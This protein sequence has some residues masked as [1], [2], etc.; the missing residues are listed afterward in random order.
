MEYINKKIYYHLQ[1]RKMWNVGDIRFV[2]QETNYYNAYFDHNAHNYEDPVTHEVIPLLDMV[3]YLEYYL[4]NGQKLNQSYSCDII[5][6]IKCIRNVLF[7]YARFFREH[8]F[9]EVRAKSFP[10]YPS[11]KTGL[12]VISDKSDI[13]YWIKTLGISVSSGI[14]LELSLTGKIHEASHESIKLNTNSFN[15]IRHQGLKYWMEN[16]VNK[17]PFVG[18]ECIFEGVAEVIKQTPV[19][20]FLLSSNCSDF[21]NDKNLESLSEVVNL[22]QLKNLILNRWDLSNTYGFPHWQRVA[23]NGIMLGD[24]TVNKTVIILFAFLHDAFRIDEKSDIKHGER[25]AKE[26]ASLRTDLLHNLSDA[27]YKLLLDACKL[28]STAATTGNPTIDTCLDANRLDLIR[29]GVDI[30]PNPALM[31]T[32]K[33]KYYAEHLEDFIKQS[34]HDFKK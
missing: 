29:C 7:N 2:G 34:G 6:S 22:K 20:D 13:P 28:H 23:R 17:D 12:S 5:S 19:K 11:R 24:D 31:S 3:L 9:E 15:G 18:N 21:D 27:E 4:N 8:L 14:L 26:L 16:I 32:K 25:S 10:D 33:G 1:R 30:R